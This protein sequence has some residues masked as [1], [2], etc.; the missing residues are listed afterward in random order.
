MVKILI[1]SI[2]SFNLFFISCYA[3]VSKPSLDETLDNGLRLIVYQDNRAPTVVQMAVVNV[4]SIDEVDGKSGVAHVLEHMMFKRTKNMKE[5]EFSRRINLM[6]GKD[7]AFTSK[8]MTGYHQ[9]VHK[10]SIKEIMSLEADRM[11][12]LI[13]DDDDFEKEINV[14]LQE[15]LLRTDDN[16]RGLAFETLLAQAF[17]AS[18]VRRPIIGWRDDIENL[19][20]D[21]AKDWYKNW[22]APNNIILIIAGDVDPKEIYQLTKELYGKASKISLPKRK[23]QT[24][25]KQI[26]KR[27]LLVKAP[28]KNKFLMKLWK[29]PAI[30]E[31]SGPM[32]YSNQK[33]RDVLALGVLSSLISDSDTGIL[34][35][36][37]VRE[38]KKALSLSSG[39]TWVSRGPGYFILQ[40][41][42]YD[43]VSLQ[44][45]ESEIDYEIKQILEEGISTEKL[46]IL[47][48]QAKADQVFQ[49]DSIMSM[50]RE[51]AMLASAGRP[52]EDADNWLE[53]LSK[54]TSEDI[55]SVGRKVFIDDNM[56]V[57]E[58]I[59]L[60][61][62]SKSKN[63]VS[64][65]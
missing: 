37:L 43:N 65:F 63:P 20:S 19:V 18:P 7:N 8:E 5:G 53:M 47:I 32:E 39:S 9:Q 61:L 50:V 24:E 60:D 30:S 36:K 33:A 35:K 57:L 46:Q 29:A 34:V 25:P 10:D 41:T 45:L 48:R 58:F 12:N 59:P 38:N 55:K 27:R 42:P 3:S 22:Y 15:R 13:I 28:A 62:Y 54:L 40:A 16:P 23:P 64:K 44:E 2:I 51:A 52:L 56:T 26:G 14:V 11:Q 49:R 1:S 6:G 4:G 21:D 17:L 31:N